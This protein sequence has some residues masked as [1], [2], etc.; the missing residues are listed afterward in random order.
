MDSSNIILNNFTF[1]FDDV[2]RPSRV[3][4]ILYVDSA[5]GEITNSI[6]QNLENLDSDGIEYAFYSAGTLDNFSDANRMKMLIENNTLIDTGRIGI[7]AQNLIDL[8]I[9]N[10]TITNNHLDFGYGIELG[11][12]ASGTI[13][14][15]VISG[16]NK[17]A[18]DG[19]L[20]GGLLIAPNVFSYDR[21]EP[22]TVSVTI[23]GNEVKDSGVAVNIGSN[24][25]NLSEDDI[26][27]DIILTNNNFHDNMGGS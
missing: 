20:S 27:L 9:H 4:G 5:G 10:N 12:K 24:W 15:N 17:T 3:A 23:D 1:D 13:T 25:C 14:N 6:L 2:E 26:D 19:S 22:L 11:N 16:F 21:D 18:H 8:T 7:Y